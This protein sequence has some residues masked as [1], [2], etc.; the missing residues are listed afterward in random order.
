MLRP[1]RPCLEACLR[2]RDKHLAERRARA[3]VQLRAMANCERRIDHARAEVFAADD[4]VVTRRMTDLEREWRKLSSPDPE[5][6]LMDLWA[7]I[8]PSSWIDRKRFRD[9]DVGT[10]L[11]AVVALSSDPDGVEAAERAVTAL[12]STLAPYGVTLGTKLRWRALSA[13]GECLEPL[14]SPALEAARARCPQKIEARVLARADAVAAKVEQA[15][16]GH[17]PE[18]PG[19]AADLGR[20][21]RLDFVW[22]A[23]SLP[24]PGNPASPLAMLYRTGYVLVAADADG[25]TLAFPDV[26]EH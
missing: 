2:Q 26:G 19:L 6:G 17:F 9:G 11:D 12:G 1:A 23:A 7:Q 14:V 20:A 21:A 15:L 10:M 5:A 24:E 4:G 13:D 22:R 25:V 8:A 18:R 3:G 16:G